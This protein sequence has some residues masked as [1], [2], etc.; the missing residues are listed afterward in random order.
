MILHKKSCG[1]LIR[2]RRN[3]PGFGFLE[4]LYELSIVFYLGLKHL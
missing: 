2:P 1:T 3:S 4:F